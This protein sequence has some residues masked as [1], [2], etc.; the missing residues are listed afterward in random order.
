MLLQSSEDAAPPAAA[1]PA[2]TGVGVRAGGGG[3]LFGAAA[4]GGCFGAGA[5]LVCHS[6]GA[7][8]LPLRSINIGAAA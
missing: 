2:A 6:G 4:C 8:D 1:C 3:E 5:S 7:R